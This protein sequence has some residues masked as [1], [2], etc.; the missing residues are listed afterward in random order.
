MALIG[1]RWVQ[2]TAKTRPNRAKC[3][4]TS[5]PIA[6]AMPTCAAASTVTSYYCLRRFRGHPE[7]PCLLWDWHTA[8]FPMVGS[9]DGTSKPTSVNRQPV[10]AW[11][12]NLP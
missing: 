12:P 9:M 5:A 6:V 3:I 2:F 10:Q 8:S 11:K 1:A 4:A 7:S